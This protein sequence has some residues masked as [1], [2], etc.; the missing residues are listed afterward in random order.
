MFHWLVE[1]CKKFDVQIFATTHSLDAID[2]MLEAEG[3]DHEAIMAFRLERYE[4]RLVAEKFGGEMLRRVRFEYGL[5]VR[6]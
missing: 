1:A 2:A 6:G 3:L 5:D 4:G